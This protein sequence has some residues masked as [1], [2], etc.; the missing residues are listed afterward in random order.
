MTL[1][2]TNIKVKMG[3]IIQRNYL[4]FQ[5]KNYRNCKTFKKSHLAKNKGFKP[6]RVLILSKMIKNIVSRQK[7]TRKL[8]IF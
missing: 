6:L 5:I 8:S 3:N 4:D 2:W 7:M 1:Y